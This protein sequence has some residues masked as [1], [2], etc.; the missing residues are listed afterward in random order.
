L[1]RAATATA[2]SLQPIAVDIDDDHRQFVLLRLPHALIGG[3]YQ[4]KC[5]LAQCRLH[6]GK[7]HGDQKKCRERG[8]A[9]HGRDALAQNSRHGSVS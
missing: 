2:R 3:E 1:F 5:A 8:E 6:V 9:G 7:E 4:V